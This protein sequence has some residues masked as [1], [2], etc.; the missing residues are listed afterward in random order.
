MA[1]NNRL[2][3]QVVP[4]PHTYQ[5][6]QANSTW[7]QLATRVHDGLNTI[8][9]K[10]NSNQNTKRTITCI[11]V[12]AMLRMMEYLGQAPY[13]IA[14][15]LQDTNFDRL[16]RAVDG[17]DN[18]ILISAATPDGFY[19]Y[20]QVDCFVPEALYIIRQNYATLVNKARAIGLMGDTLG[21]LGLGTRSVGTILFAGMRA[22][23]IVYGKCIENQPYNDLYACIFRDVSHEAELSLPG[24]DQAVYNRHM[25]TPSATRLNYWDHVFLGELA[26]GQDTHTNTSA[27][28]TTQTHLRQPHTHTH[29]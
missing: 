3:I 6:P 12:S 23:M 13:V 5:H 27:H 2:K 21:G 14:E 10:G 26:E 19:D 20:T 8:L 29:H 7:A 11:W 15:S 17:V 25:L 16:A 1:Y 18:R 22:Y 24:A 9:L 28:A 4:T